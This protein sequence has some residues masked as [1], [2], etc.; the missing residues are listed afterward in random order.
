MTAAF[1]LKQLSI[2]NGSLLGDGH[3]SRSRGGGNSYFSKNQCIAHKEYL[4][5]LSVKMGKWSS[6]LV[7]Y[8]NFCHGKAHG[9]VRFLSKTH[10]VFTALRWHWYPEGTKIV[11]RDLV[12]DPL[13]IAIWFADDGSNNVGK[14]QARFSTD[15]FS[16]IDCAFLCDLLAEY[17]VHAYVIKRNVVQVS[18]RS[19]KTLIDLIRPHIPWSCFAHKLH[20]RDPAFEC[21]TDVEAREIFRLRS[22][23]LIYRDISSR[24]GKS[25]SVV[26]AIL[27]GDRMKHLGAAHAVQGLSLSNTSGRPGVSWDRSRAK[28]KASV[29]RQGKSIHL[30]RYATKEEAAAAVERLIRSGAYRH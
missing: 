2:L 16:K 30:G 14:R 21:T 25:I 4:D 20:Y 26:S 3:L 9:A 28:W 18:A 1:S 8:T 17:Q 12:L 7:E 29:K 23:G 6:S 11:P 10:P 22:Q 19:Y 24:V 15:C 27:R 5:W 13:S